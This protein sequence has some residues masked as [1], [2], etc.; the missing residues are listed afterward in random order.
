MFNIVVLEGMVLGQ[1]FL[2]QRPQA[3]DVPLAVAQ[4]VDEAAFGL[5]LGDA[6]FPV[7]T[8]VRGPYTQALVEDEERLSQR[9]DDVVGVGQSGLHLL[10]GVPALAD[11]PEHQHHTGDFAPLVADRGGAVVNRSVRPVFGDEQ[12]VVRQPDDHAIPQG[13]NRG[14]LDCLAAVFV[15]DVKHAVERLAHGL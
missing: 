3:G 8:G 2:Q 12:A 4:L 14:T 6:E 9:R 13:S 5:L 7:E 15:D 10:L 1:D 11:V